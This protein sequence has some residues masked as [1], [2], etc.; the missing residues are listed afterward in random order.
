MNDEQQSQP[1]ELEIKFSVPTGA[2]TELANHPALRADGTTP[3]QTRSEVTTYFDT[4]D[5]RLR[6]GAASLRV[7]RR[8]EQRVQTLKLPSATATAFG[9]AEWEWPVHG[10]VPDLRCLAETPLG[11]K[12]SHRDELGAVFT[13]EI[14]RT[15]YIVRIDDATIEA[16]LDLGVIRAGEATEEVRELELELKDGSAASLYRLA[17]ALQSSLQLTLGAES[18][19]DRGWRLR[20]GRTRGPVKQ[21]DIRLEPDVTAAVAFRHIVATSLANL[22]ANQPAALIG[23]IEGIHHMRVAIRRLR[24][25]LAL[26]RPHLEPHAEARF[27]AELRRIG[28]VL[29]EARDWDVFCAETLV[30]AGEDGVPASLLDLLRGPAEA[31]RDEAHREVVA[32][33]NGPAFTSLVLGLAAWAEDAATLAAPPS[34]EAMQLLMADLAPLLEARLARKALRRGRH[35]RGRTAEELHALR[36]SLKKLRYGI[37]FMAPLHRRKQVKAYLRGCK[38]LQEQ[39]GALNDGTMAVRMGEELGEDRVAALAPAIAALANWA[40]A[41]R[42]RALKHLP[43][44]WNA[45]KTVQLPT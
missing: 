41:R 44:G 40:Q 8:G 13:S 21:P 2:E 19:A 22:L 36:K 25:V 20:T 14:Q 12:L 23:E 42:A 34:R 9:R 28:R 4:P 32:E 35:I 29:G 43:D 30:A 15:T 45:F 39:L 10:E 18:K 6:A 37:E 24:A 7:R 27:T 26:F 11:T 1:I 31:R 3:P 38:A 5:C 33:L 16:A 17:T